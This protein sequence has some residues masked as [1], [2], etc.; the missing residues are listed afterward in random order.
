M[1]S[2]CLS[3][4]SCLLRRC[5]SCRSESFDWIHISAVSDPQKLEAGYQRMPHCARCHSKCGRS[6]Q[7]FTYRS[8]TLIKTPTSSTLAGHQ[9]DGDMCTSIQPLLLSN[10][11]LD[12][13][14]LVAE[15]PQAPPVMRGAPCWQLPG[16]AEQQCHQSLTAAPESITYTRTRLYQIDQPRSPKK[17]CL[18]T[19]PGSYRT[20]ARCGR[21]HSRSCIHRL[22]R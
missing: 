9:L 21:Q 5:R 1:T 22:A 15:Q 14:M 18:L 19:T 12:R 13:G 16:L 8:R 10:S 3:S 7:M 6:R 17:R 11:K 4:P 2:S 20:I